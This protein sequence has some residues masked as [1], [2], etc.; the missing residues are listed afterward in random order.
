MSD[1]AVG[2]VTKRGNFVPWSSQYECVSEVPMH[3][4]RKIDGAAVLRRIENSEKLEATD[5]P[6]EETDGDA[7]VMRLH[8]R[9]RADGT[10]GWVSIRG[11]KGRPHLVNKR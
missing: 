5:A 1:G 2:W 4:A 10:E 8:A 7:V 3:D 9:A 6:V 11:P